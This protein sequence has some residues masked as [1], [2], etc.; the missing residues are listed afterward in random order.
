[1][2]MGRR[3]DPEI[4]DRRKR[5]VELEK[6]GMNA[7]EIAEKMGVPKSKVARVNRWL[8]RE[9]GS[10]P[11]PFKAEIVKRLEA[12]MAIKQIAEEVGC[13]EKNVRVLEKKMRSKLKIQI[14]DPKDPD[15]WVDEFIKDPKSKKGE[16]YTRYESF[17]TA[18]IARLN[19]ET[20]T[21]PQTAKELIDLAIAQF[22]VKRERA[23]K[24]EQVRVFTCNLVH[25]TAIL[26]A[27]ERALQ[28]PEPA[29]VILD[30]AQDAAADCQACR[31]DLARRR[32]LVLR[33]LKRYPET[34][35][36]LAISQNHYR[37][38][39]HNGH[40]GLGNGLGSCAL[41][42][43]TTHY[44][45]GSA[46]VAIKIAESALEGSVQPT[47][48]FLHFSLRFASALALAEIPERLEDTKNLAVDL[49]KECDHNA[50][51]LRLKTIW[52]AGRVAELEGRHHVAKDHYEDAYDYA[53]NLKI[54][55]A[56]GAVLADLE[57][58]SP[59]PSSLKE[60]IR[61]LST[62]QKKAAFPGY[63]NPLRGS[64]M[65]AYHATSSGEVAMALRRL[66]REAGGDKALP[67]SAA[68][69]TA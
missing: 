36:Q 37:S 1:M 2:G 69:A 61:R 43:A 28:R 26:A 45:N 41:A 22:R 18:F 63:L 17:G 20:N 19:R 34:F 16:R 38:L 40:D 49:L 57:G 10:K 47:E 6:Q 15:K 31:A 44:Y 13:T 25:A 5:A 4:A 32:A 8:L 65:S 21:N 14:V 68:M 59:D 55:P 29:L 27:R 30:E 39:G 54:A 60:R 33:D 52:F 62:N 66:R 12:G 42:L 56:I 35:A 3:P 64:L 11:P 67:R 46:S 51:V 58:L 24:P 9:R 53:I 48:K 7:L 50:G 23:R